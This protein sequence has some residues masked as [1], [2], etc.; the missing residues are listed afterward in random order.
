MI[1]MLLSHPL[2]AITAKQARYMGYTL[3]VLSASHCFDY[4]G[5]TRLIANHATNTIPTNNH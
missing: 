4:R 1:A 5:C 3:L 2:Q